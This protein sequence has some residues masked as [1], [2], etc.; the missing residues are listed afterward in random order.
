MKKLQLFLFALLIFISTTTFAQIQGQPKG[1]M[2]MK[3][4]MTEI[5]TTMPPIVTPG[6]TNS[7]APSDAIVLFG[8]NTNLN[9]WM[10]VKDTNLA[11]PWTVYND[12]FEVKPGTGEIKTKR[13]FGDIQLHIEW[14]E[15][16]LDSAKYKGQ[17]KGN[18]GVF[19][20]ENYELQVLDSYQN[21]TYYNG[22]AGSIYK[23]QPPL[24]NP[25]RPPGE[26][27]A[28]DVVYTA[29]KFKKN[30]KLDEPARITVFFNGVL[31]QNNTTIQGLTQYIGLHYYPAAHGEGSLKLQDHGHLVKFRNVWV[32]EL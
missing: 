21:S 10:S 24:V 32:R 14:S 31:V 12:Y 20:Q 27:N 22:M 4:E 18:S 13:K 15:P 19:F 7:D 6:K 23:D 28:Y 17:D 3:P 2:P 30:G 11:A 25:I 16:F 5:Y 29:P 1:V 9:E 26:W 8:K